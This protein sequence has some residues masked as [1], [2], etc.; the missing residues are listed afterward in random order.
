MTDVMIHIARFEK[1][2]IGQTF[3]L[4]VLKDLNDTPD[5]E[6][7]KINV[8]IRYAE[9]R[10]G[11]INIQ[12][13]KPFTY[14]PLEAGEVYIGWEQVTKDYMT[15]GYDRNEDSSEEIFFNTGAVWESFKDNVQD[16]EKGSLMIRPVFGDE[17]IAAL[18]DADKWSFQIFPNPTQG[19]MYIQGNLPKKIK[20]YHPTG[21]LILE[22]NMDTTLDVMELNIQDLPEG[23]YILQGIF[24][25]GQSTS[26]KIVIQ[27]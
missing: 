8:P 23:I 20:I 24:K 15:V 11:F 6:L 13:I 9:Q 1:D 5:S 26:Q 7:M 17:T 14:L 21:Q 16:F 10:N 2:L 19:K 25:N 12:G 22:K 27:K 3:N 18:P 4:L